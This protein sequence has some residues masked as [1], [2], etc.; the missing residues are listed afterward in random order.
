[1]RQPELPAEKLT[2]LS[3]LGALRAEESLFS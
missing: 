1:M 3:F 2:I